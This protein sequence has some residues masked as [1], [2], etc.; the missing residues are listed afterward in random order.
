MANSPV[1]MTGLECLMYKH[2]NQQI[3][4]S[5]RNLKTNENI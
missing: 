1:L 2:I 5:L 4:V 3:M